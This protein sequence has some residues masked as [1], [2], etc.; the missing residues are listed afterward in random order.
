MRLLAALRSFRLVVPAA[1]VACW[2]LLAAQQASARVIYEPVRFQYGQQQ[3]YYYGGS[4]PRMFALAESPVAA[5]GGWGRVN[6]FDFVANRIGIVR[7]V[8]VDDLRTFTDALPGYNAATFGYTANDA[9]NEAYARLPTYFTKRQLL[10]AAVRVSPNTFIVPATAPEPRP[11][12]AGRGSILIRP[13]TPRPYTP[14]PAAPAAE[15]VVPEPAFILPRDLLDEP[16][17]LLVLAA[18]H[19][20]LG[21]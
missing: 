12:Q 8:A 14:R 5:G 7:E 17:D 2:S 9:R 16:T 3:T 1:L 21:V 15:P 6:G 10:Q 4:D 13:Y 19:H 20:P 11:T 18:R